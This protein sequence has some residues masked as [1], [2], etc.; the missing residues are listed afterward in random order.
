MT[1]G[2]RTDPAPAAAGSR[3][4]RPLRADARRNAERVLAGARRAVA[5]LGLDVSYHDIARRAGVGVGTV[6]RRFPDRAR[7]LE[8][9]LLDVIDELSAHARQALRGEDPWSEFVG[10][11]GT[12]AVRIGEN[13]GLSDSLQERGGARVAAARDRLLRLVRELVDRAR[14]AGSLREDI[15]WQDVA[16]LAAS[17]PVAGRCF[18][19]LETT[20]QQVQRCIAV[21]TDGLHR[22]PP[23]SLV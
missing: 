19:D 22:C 3:P 2:L 7:L 16:A 20:P 5:D 1:D 11:F 18:L 9:V 6:Y 13:A 15:R 10:F 12:L 4:V 17:I 8:A 21:L 14:R 23:Q